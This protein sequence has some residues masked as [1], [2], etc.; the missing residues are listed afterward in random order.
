[1]IKTI[2]NTSIFLSS[3]TYALAQNTIMPVDQLEAE[4][5]ENFTGTAVAYYEDGEPKLWREMVDGKAS[6]F[7]LEW[8]ENGNLRY[9]AEWHAGKGHG[10]WQYF[11]E[12]G[13]LRSDEIY[14]NDINQGIGLNYHPNGIVAK[15]TFHLDGK[16]HGRWI[17]YDLNGNP[18]S[19]QLYRDGDLI[20]EGDYTN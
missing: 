19:Y 5:I 2:I 17:S 10:R 15:Q 11:Y 8:Y 20:E 12:N 1:M 16:K 13:Q 14:Q 4:Q 18:M 7:W 6:G 9:K 3:I